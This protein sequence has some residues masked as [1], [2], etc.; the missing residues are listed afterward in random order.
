MTQRIKRHP[1]LAL[2]DGPDTN[3][4]TGSRQVTTVPTQALF[5]LNDPFVHARA[6]S[7][8]RRLAGLPSDAARLE[9]A[10]L[11]LYGRPASKKEQATAALFLAASLRELGGLGPE[12]QQQAWASWLRVML[13]ANEFIYVD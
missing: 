1:F 5:F 9:R 13:S 8:T 4:S 10:C 6:D 11:L 7:L 3:A 12:K 2:F